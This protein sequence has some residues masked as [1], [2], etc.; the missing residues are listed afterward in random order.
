MTPVS[1]HVEINKISCVSPYHNT[2]VPWGQPKHVRF[3][4][5]PKIQALCKST[6]DILAIWES[7]ELAEEAICLGCM[8]LQVDG[9]CD[10]T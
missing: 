2:D 6:E 4:D 10:L 9:S 1:V 3:Q 8:V 7:E 5:D